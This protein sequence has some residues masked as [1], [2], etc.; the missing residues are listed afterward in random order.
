MP[1]TAFASVR[2]SALLI[3]SAALHLAS[4][5][6]AG[7]QVSMGHEKTPL[8]LLYERQD[9]E[10]QE[11][12]RAYEQQMRRLKAQAPTTTSSDPWKGVRP[13]PDTSKK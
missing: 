8:E 11:N 13:S 10:R 6:G 12:E 1:V 3:V 4:L 7:A 9:K 2:V 5:S